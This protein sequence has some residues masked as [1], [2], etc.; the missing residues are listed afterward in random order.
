MLNL[1]N[2]REIKDIISRLKKTALHSRKDNQEIRDQVHKRYR[3]NILFAF[4]LLAISITFCFCWQI[5]A[6][7]ESSPDT[8][9]SAFTL[10][11]AIV[12]GLI[13]FVTGKAV[14]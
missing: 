12:S 1:V 10:V 9:K 2:L 8:I 11:T 6:N 4:T 14:G 3:T 13:G 5:I 7:P